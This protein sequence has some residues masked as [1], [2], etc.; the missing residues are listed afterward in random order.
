MPEY[1]PYEELQRQIDVALEALEDRR[2]QRLLSLGDRPD[3]LADALR[4][5]LLAVGASMGE[6]REDVP[7]APMH[8]VRKADGTMIWCCAHV[9]PH[10][11]SCA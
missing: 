6:C 11:E 8:P 3:A 2:S 4:T 9:P 10:P 7:Y 5:T 1:P